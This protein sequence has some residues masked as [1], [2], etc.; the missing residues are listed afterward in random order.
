MWYGTFI[1]RNFNRYMVLL[2][3]F[4]NVSIHDIRYMEELRFLA[5]SKYIQKRNQRSLLI[6]QLLRYT[7][8]GPIILDEII[9]K[10]I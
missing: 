9:N 10:I 8:C 4:H 5:N 6:L 3:L 7:L 1:N 2:M